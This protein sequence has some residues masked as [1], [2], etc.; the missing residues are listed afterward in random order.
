MY[1]HIS[2]DHLAKT[3]SIPPSHTYYQEEKL[4]DRYDSDGHAHPIESIE[5]MSDDG[6]YHQCHSI[7]ALNEDIE[8]R[9]AA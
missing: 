8:E 5:V 6:A 4:H 7:E 3:I 2:H 9:V 1:G